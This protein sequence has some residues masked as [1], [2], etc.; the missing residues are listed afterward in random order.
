M[1]FLYPYYKFRSSLGTLKYGALS[2]LLFFIGF[3]SFSQDG[4]SDAIRFTS[5]Q[6]N[7]SSDCNLPPVSLVSFKAR[8]KNNLVRLDWTAPVKTNTSHFIV[9]RSLDGMEF[10]DDAIVFTEGTSSVPKNYSFSDNI[11]TINCRQIFY[12]LKIVGR[13]EQYRYSDIVSLSL[14]ND[15]ELAVHFIPNYPAFNE[16]D[17]FMKQHADSNPGLIESSAFDGLPSVL[18]FFRQQM[19]D[20]LS[21]KDFQS[22]VKI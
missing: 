5:F 8:L 12:R 9:Q 21:N 1:L 15:F 7:T 18:N 6:R 20:K 4:I 10:N 11:N 14:Q 13:D 17:S 16:Y 2:F 3:S 22:K 19:P